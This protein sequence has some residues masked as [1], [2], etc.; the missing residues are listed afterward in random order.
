MKISIVLI[1]GRRVCRAQAIVDSV[2][3]Q[4][5]IT[6]A[7]LII[8]DCFNTCSQVSF[9]SGLDYTIINERIAGYGKLRKIGID[10]ARGEYVAFVEEHTIVEPNWLNETLKTFDD[11]DCDGVGGAMITMNDQFNISQVLGIINFLKF[12]PP[13][14]SMAS[15]SLPGYNNAFR[16]EVINQLDEYLLEYEPILY[17][18]LQKRGCHLMINPA[19]RF[20]HAFENDWK[21]SFR[22]S[23]IYNQCFASF[24]K[25]YYRWGIA[26]LI[27]RILAV[28]LM[29]FSRTAKDL[30]YIIR[31]K[32]P[33]LSLALKRIHLIFFLHSAASLGSLCGYFSGYQGLREKFTLIEL[34]LERPLG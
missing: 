2:Q 9:R 16:K 10:K 14:N 28:P 8:I 34:D 1:I 33:L 7:E 11:H 30:F 24:R 29:P 19:I 18:E 6:D 22:V 3:Y 26:K 31:F 13:V 15:D 23:K 20:Q 27:F 32:K 25:K 5:G 21:L 4:K 17:W 12:H